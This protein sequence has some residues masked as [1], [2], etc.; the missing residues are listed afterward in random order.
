M[1]PKISRSN[2]ICLLLVPRE[3]FVAV[4]REC[5]RLYEFEESEEF[6][7]FEESEEFDKFEESENDPLSRSSLDSLSGLN[8]YRTNRTKEKSF[9]CQI[10]SFHD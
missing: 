5:P 9:E 1:T 8:V 6:E 4:P 3:S 7:E 10:F 2:L